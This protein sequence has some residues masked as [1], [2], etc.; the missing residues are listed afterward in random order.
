M[1]KVVTDNI[2]CKTCLN[3]G[4][5]TMWK[6]LFY[7]MDKLYKQKCKPP[8]WMQILIFESNSSDGF[9][10]VFGACYSSGVKP[11]HWSINLG[12]LGKSIVVDRAILFQDISFKARH[13]R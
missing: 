4:F 3:T 11:V 13:R 9:F 12:K 10:N 7:T 6:I 1:T 8:A 2:F 5:E